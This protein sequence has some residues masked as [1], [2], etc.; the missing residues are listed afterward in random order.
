MPGRRLHWDELEDEVDR[1]GGPDQFAIGEDGALMGPREVVIELPLVLARPTPDQ[2][3]EDYLEALPEA[4]GLHL[5]VLMQSGAA[6]LALFDEGCC[7]DTKTIKKYTVRGQGRAQDAYL[8]TRGKSRYGSRL[9]LRNAE[10]LLAQLSEKLLEWIDIYGRPE[11]LFYSAPIRM[12][13]D[14]FVARNAMP[15]GREAGWVRI[16]LDLPAPTSELARRVYERLCHGRI[17]QR[18]DRS[19]PRAG[20]HPSG[21][22]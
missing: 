12:W 20:P 8:K 5:V 1:L 3:V 14:L 10:S 17:L 15:I 2:A 4:L 13:S 18:D 9:R 22:R 7:L 19:H 6:S 11:R 21:D 16:P